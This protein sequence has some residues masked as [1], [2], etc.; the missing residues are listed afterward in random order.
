MSSAAPELLLQPN[1]A[2]TYVAMNYDLPGNT[3]V[4]QVR[5]R[6]ASGRVVHTLQIAGEQGQQVWDTRGTA[7]GVYT[8]E[9]LREGRV[10]RSER[11]VIQP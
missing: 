3:S 7:P 6:D 5:V 4:A 2:S 1:P 10:E 11:L 9:L 8:V